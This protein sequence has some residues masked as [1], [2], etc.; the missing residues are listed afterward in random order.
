MVPRPTVIQNVLS[1]RT[2][3]VTRHVYGIVALILVQVPAAWMPYATFS[4]ITQFAL[5]LMDTLAIH[6]Q[7]VIQNC[8]MNSHHHH[9]TNV[10]HLH[11]ARMLN[12]V[13]AFVRVCPSSKAIHTLAV[14]PNAFWTP[15]VR[16]IKPVCIK[17]ASIHALDLVRRTQFV[18][19]SITCL[20][21]VVPKEWKETPSFNVIQR[22]VNI[23]AVG[24][25]KKWSESSA[26]FCEWILAPEVIRP[27]QPSPCGPN[28]ECREVNGQAVCY[29]ILSYIGSPPACRPECITNSDC[30]QNEACHNQK[31][32]DPCPGVCGMNAKCTVINHN[33]MCTCIP[34]YS[35]DP[36]I[37]CQMNSK[38][39]TL[40]CCSI[41]YCKINLYSFISWATATTWP[42]RSML[43]ISVR[44][45]FRM[46][47]CRRFSVMLMFTTVHW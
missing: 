36:F 3:L 43:P 18:M 34:H 46:P 31:C 44:S 9:Q 2:V 15:I 20:C 7:T 22:R 47:E 4:I 35:G 11:A 45:S 39:L 24:L 5:A 27:C 12:A 42:C 30:P 32:R 28:S 13:M 38:M 40:I 37:R 6:S 8:N 19:L 41:M 14:V 33:P 1:M 21:V 17:N 16:K 29:C 23:L 26:L 25:K 10:I